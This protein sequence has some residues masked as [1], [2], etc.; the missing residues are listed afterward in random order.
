M[1]GKHGCAHLVYGYEHFDDRILKLMGK[2]STR[3]TNI[4]SFFW[5]LEA[6]YEDGYWDNYHVGG[7]GI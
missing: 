5:T 6:L 4:R 3:K 1:M 2:V 7:V